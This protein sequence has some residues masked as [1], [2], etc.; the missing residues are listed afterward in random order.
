MVAFAFLGLGAG[1][2]CAKTLAARNTTAHDFQR[3]FI[4]LSFLKV[5]YLG[6]NLRGN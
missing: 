3:E 2:S 6:L 1:L 4:H 5:R